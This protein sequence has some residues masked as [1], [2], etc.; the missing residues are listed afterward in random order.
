MAELQEE[1]TK[2]RPGDKVKVKII[3]DKKEKTI[4]VELKNAQ[5][6]TNVVKNVDMDILGGAFKEL[7][8]ELKRQLNLGYGLQV[9]GLTDGKMKDAGIRKGV[10]LLKANNQP[11]RQV[12]DLEEVLKRK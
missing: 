10:I 2:R 5:G 8:D 4:T 9:T 6:N 12:S 7:P 3:R 11:L 1:L